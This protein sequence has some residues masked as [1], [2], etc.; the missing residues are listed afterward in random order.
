[1]NPANRRPPI[2]PLAY[3][4][5]QP[6]K[7]L[8]QAQH[9]AEHK[10]ELISMGTREARLRLDRAASELLRLGQ[11]CTLHCPLI[12]NGTPLAPAH[13]TVEWL[14]GHEAGLVFTIRASHSISA[15]QHAFS[16]ETE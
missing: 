11:R 13:C 1:M 9:G 14:H 6:C 15:L 7:L 10:A 16:K 3:G 2:R 8:A 5:G 12:L 4:R